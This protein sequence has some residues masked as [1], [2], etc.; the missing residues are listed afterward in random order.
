[1]SQ[2][3]LKIAKRDSDSFIRNR[4]IFFH[5]SSPGLDFTVIR[6]LGIPTDSMHGKRKG[7]RVSRNDPWPGLGQRRVPSPSGDTGRVHKDTA[8]WGPG[9]LP[10]TGRITARRIM[11]PSFHIR[12]FCNPYS[13]IYN[14]PG[15]LEGLKYL[16]KMV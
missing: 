6:A 8:A 2:P 5:C 3:G 10:P 1:M 12:Q 13:L 7:I 14:S 15:S 16:K 4:K 9:R 11:L